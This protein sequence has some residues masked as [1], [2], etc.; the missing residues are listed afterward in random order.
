MFAVSADPSHFFVALPGPRQ[1]PLP[2][3][4]GNLPPSR[5]ENLAFGPPV[6]LRNAD[7]RFSKFEISLG[8][9]LPSRLQKSAA[10]AVKCAAAGPPSAA[11]PAAL[12]PSPFEPRFSLLGLPGC[13]EG[14][15]GADAQSHAARARASHLHALWTGD[16]GL[17]R[18]GRGLSSGANGQDLYHFPR[19]FFLHPYLYS[20]LAC[21]CRRPVSGVGEKAPF[22]GGDITF[23]GRPI[24][25]TLYILIPLPP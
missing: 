11:G 18:G 12:P 13:C 4:S 8:C 16:R 5:D 25:P 23:R 6:S 9:P 3:Y 1:P 15:G 17:V 19:I 7:A 10:A 20:H 22:A 14:A 21:V 2:S 24:S